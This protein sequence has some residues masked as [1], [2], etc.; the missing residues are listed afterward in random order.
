[1]LIAGTREGT[2]SS[3][4]LKAFDLHFTDYS[5]KVHHSVHCINQ[6]AQRRLLL[7]GWEEEEFSSSL[8]DIIT[9]I[10]PNSFIQG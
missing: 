2:E 6:T 8:V 7:L 10:F 3:R 1:M 5:F 9:L 4:C